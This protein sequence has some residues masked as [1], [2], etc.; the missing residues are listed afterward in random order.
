MTVIE[1]LALENR[2]EIK[3]LEWEW[4]NK[5]LTTTQVKENIEKRKYLSQSLA[6]FE[7]EISK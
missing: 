2:S 3:L 6:Y 1:R 4:L 7:N 5:D